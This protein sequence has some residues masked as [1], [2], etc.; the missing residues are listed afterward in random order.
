MH[1]VEGIIGSGALSI[2]TG[3]FAQQANAA[4]TVTYGDTVVMVTA[5]DNK[6]SYQKYDFLPLTVDYEERLYAAGKI[7]GGFLRREGRPTQEAILACRLIDR[8]IRPLF[9]KGFHH[10]VQIIVT[11]LSADRENMPEVLAIIG[12]SAALSISDIP[13]GGP[14]GAIRVGYL[15]GEYVA[16]PT[17]S[18]VQR[19]PIDLI[20]AGTKDTVVMM[21]AGSKEASEEII[22]GAIKYGQNINQEIIRLQEEIKKACGKPKAEFQHPEVDP[23]LDGALSAAL[24]DKLSSVFGKDKIDRETV[25]SCLKDEIISELG[26]TYPPADLLSAFDAKLK[27]EVRARILETGRRPDGR[28]ATEIRPISCEVGLLPRTHGSGLF[29]RGQTQ[30]L[31]ITT[32][33]SMGEEQ[34]MD[35]L[36][37]EE[38][39]HFM[40]HYN[41]P[42]F[43]VG[44]TR[45]IGTPG[46]REIGHGALAERALS[47]VIPS[48]EEFPYTIRLVSEVLS[49]NGS[50]SMA[51]V[52]GSTLSVMDAGVPVKHPVA[53]VAMGLVSSEDGKY[54]V[55]SDIE[56]M[57]DAYGD[58]DFKVAGTS[59]GIT[60][61]Q[62][63]TKLQGLTQEIIERTLTQA[64][65][66][67]SFILN[68]MQDT[69][70]A[71]RPELSKYAP[72]M[73][74]LTVPPH[75]IGAIIGP[76]GKT[77]RYITEETKVTIDVENDGSVLI[78]SSSEEA[79]QKAIAM[80]EALTK[81]V[82]AGGIYTG[83]VTRIFNYGALVE[84]LP[85]KEGLVHISELADYRVPSVE[86]VV[87][88]GDEITVVVTEIDRQGRINLSRRALLR[89]QSQAGN[90]TN[91]IRPR[92]GGNSPGDRRGPHAQSSHS[93]R[94]SSANRRSHSTGAGRP[95][96]GGRN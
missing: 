75:K 74:K 27:K 13:F 86:D 11:V 56:G 89:E 18:E 6:S 76:G 94:D 24:R 65:E 66:A 41:F 57:E 38:T 23:A 50:T 72:R 71:S 29:T 21:E 90:E 62:M 20:V 69:I 39:K 14:V 28:S 9:P 1:R 37:L 25:L 70:L 34:R 17:F 8:P 77:I 85:N 52:C 80:I 10:E 33:G 58:M 46:R 49:S 7:P 40:H 81:D 87:R 54:V 64:K 55:L 42:P 35:G 30:V 68:K 60:A 96:G 12:A 26:E 15:D 53:G 59:E 84:I 95:R 43:S 83:K 82:E 73:V 16:N 5:C 79:A 22:S 48:E 3:K 47:A 78:G 32:L 88:I 91:Q 44:E 2:E 61:L 67:R 31:T 92:D 4:V 63:D 51:S 93:D 45:R 19:S 36:T